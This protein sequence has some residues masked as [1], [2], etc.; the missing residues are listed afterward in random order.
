MIV[1][2]TPNNNAVISRIQRKRETQLQKEVHEQMRRV[3]WKKYYRFEYEFCQLLH[4]RITFD[5]LALR[6]P[7]QKRTLYKYYYKRPETRMNGMLLFDLLT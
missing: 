1:R 6:L 4:A 7:R 3:D 2:P 5:L